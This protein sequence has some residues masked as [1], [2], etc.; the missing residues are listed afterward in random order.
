MA[1]RPPAHLVPEF[2]VAVQRAIVGDHRD[3]PPGADDGRGGPPLAHGSGSTDF[4]AAST[5]RPEVG[6]QVG[7]RQALVPER[8]GQHRPQRTARGAAARSSSEPATAHRRRRCPSAI[9]MSPTATRSGSVPEV[10]TARK[11]ARDGFWPGPPVVPPHG[12]P[13]EI[14]QTRRS[15]KRPTNGSRHRRRLDKRCAGDCPAA[16]IP[17]TRMTMCD[18]ISQTPWPWTAWS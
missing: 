2:A 1:S 12:R 14:R 8:S 10:N 18:P 4:P 13:G 5:N 3:R 6:Q 9:P 15:K 7:H 16:T 11:A 17:P